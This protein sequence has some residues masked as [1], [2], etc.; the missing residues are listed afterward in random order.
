MLKT[1][2][3]CWFCNKESQV[4]LLNK[5]SWTCSSCNQYNGFNKDGDYNK[6]IPEMQTE[7]N[8][9][10]CIQR[11]NHTGSGGS[12]ISRSNENNLLCEKCNNL[13]ELKLKELNQFD[14]K[15]EDNFDEEYKIFKSKLDH[16]Y[17]L[18]KQ[19]KLRVNQHIQKQDQ[20]IGTYLSSTK[21]KQKPSL[22]QAIK[23]K[24][25]TKQQQQQQQKHLQPAASPAAVPIAKK[26][27]T[28]ACI[29]PT[30]SPN[31]G[32]VNRL[33]SKPVEKKPI[34]EPPAPPRSPS[35]LIDVE[36]E[37][38]MNKL[39]NTTKLLTKKSNK[40]SLFLIQTVLT[41]F[42]SFVGIILIF[43]SDLVN[44]INDSGVWSPENG[45]SATELDESYVYRMFLRCYKYSQLALGLII[46]VSLYFAIKR[47]K[48]S[49]FLILIGFCFNFLV[50]VNFFELKLEEK[51]ILEVFMSFFL[52]GYLTMARVYNVL[53]F[54]RYVKSE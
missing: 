9:Q 51:Y 5:N 15:N 47:P 26:A 48:V 1:K 46:G 12:R 52:A 4:F 22:P 21:E 44:L 23:S 6:S 20:Q 54:V 36:Y 14:T 53:Q 28:V 17:D 32:A 8:R 24:H 49:R 34:F 13:Q 40:I 29:T 16:I 50:H 43:F 37:Q 18:C 2:V 25:L 10:F 35:R 31:S 38:Q 39:I 27:Y 11:A 3:T 42:L 30:Q 7:S 45:T 33:I 41:D 19:C